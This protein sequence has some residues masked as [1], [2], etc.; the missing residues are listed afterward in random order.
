[1]TPE[2]ANT[3]ALAHPFL[4]A[5]KA[6][7]YRAGLVALAI[8]PRRQAIFIGHPAAFDPDVRSVGVAYGI[9]NDLLAAPEE[10]MLRRSVHLSGKQIDVEMDDGRRHAFR[11]SAKRR[12]EVSRLN[13]AGGS[14]KRGSSAYLVMLFVGCWRV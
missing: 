5:A 6:V 2:V 13:L 14:H 11:Y 1:L 3:A 7:P 10:D 4:D 8:V 9:R 12:C